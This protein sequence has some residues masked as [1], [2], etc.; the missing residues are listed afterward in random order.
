LAYFEYNG[1]TTD[2]IISTPLILVVQDGLDEIV[3]TRSKIE[4]ER[5]ISRYVTNEYGT[6][7]DSL[8]FQITLMKDQFKPPAM[9]E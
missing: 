5:T 1:K 4:G 3:T 7:Y 8:S 6:I 2:N 9:T